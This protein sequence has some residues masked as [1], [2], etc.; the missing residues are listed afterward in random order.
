[1]RRLFV[2]RG[3]PGTI[4]GPELR[5]PQVELMHFHRR[6][7]IAGVVVIVAFGGLLGRFIYL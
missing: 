7:L 1:M 6:L 4:S 5:N 3:R 2:N